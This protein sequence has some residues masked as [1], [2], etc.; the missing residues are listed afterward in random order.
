MGHGRMAGDDGRGTTTLIAI[1]VKRR[2][3]DRQ[4]HKSLLRI[5]VNGWIDGGVL[6]ADYESR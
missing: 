3:M 1:A 5:L 2:E 4:I 6:P